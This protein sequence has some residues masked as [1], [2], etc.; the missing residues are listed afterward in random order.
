MILCL[1]G[2]ER[3]GIGGVAMVPVMADVCWVAVALPIVVLRKR[4]LTG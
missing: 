3:L 1:D 4:H 2:I